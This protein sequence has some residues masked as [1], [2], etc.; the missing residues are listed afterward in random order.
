MSKSPLPNTNNHYQYKR[1]Q[2][3]SQRRNTQKRSSRVSQF[4]KEDQIFNEIIKQT[5]IL[6]VKVFSFEKED[7]EIEQDY[8]NQFVRCSS[9]KTSSNLPTANNSREQTPKTSFDLD[10]TQ[11][12]HFQNISFQK[13]V[14]DK[15]SNRKW[16]KDSSSTYDSIDEQQHFVN[17]QQ[18]R[19]K[20]EDFKMKYK[21]ELCK[22]FEINGT[23]KFGDNV[24]TSYI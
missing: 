15:L 1:Y 9:R 10:D 11:N 23:C 19:P 24:R 14:Y 5:S 6:P 4:Q 13:A 22:Y 16:S 3:Q 21:T 17:Q 2:F 8:S 18:Y 20:V 12:Q 7:I